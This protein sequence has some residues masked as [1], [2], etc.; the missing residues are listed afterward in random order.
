[1]IVGYRHHKT[2]EIYCAPCAHR[3]DLDVETEESPF[4]PV[5]STDEGMGKRKCDRCWF[6]LEKANTVGVCPT[7][8]RL[9]TY[10]GGVKI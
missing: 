6:L 2:G 8:G 10:G 5:R 7:C 1:M 3:I 9:R 4:E